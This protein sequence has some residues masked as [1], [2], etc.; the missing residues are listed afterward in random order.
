MA[1]YATAL[2]GGVGR[3]GGSQRPPAQGLPQH[4]ITLFQERSV[5]IDLR[6][7]ADTYT[8]EER[9]GFLRD[10]LGLQTGDIR[11]IFLD[12]STLLLHVALVKHTTFAALR[13]RLF[14]GVKWTAVGDYTVYGWAAAEPL[15]DVRVTGVPKR[16]PSAL[17]RGHFES[18]G[19]VSQ[20][21]RD[22]DR[23]WSSA[24]NGVVRISVRLL[25][26]AV[27][28]HFV[29]VVDSQG[30]LCER[31]AV[32]IN[33]RRRHCFRCGGPGHLGPFCKASCISS[34]APP[35]L[36]STLTYDGPGAATP[37]AAASAAASVTVVPSSIAVDAAISTA[38]V[39]AALSCATG[40]AAPSSAVADSAISAAAIAAAPSRAA[41]DA[42]PSSAV[43]EAVVSAAAVAAVPPGA[44]VDAAPSSVVLEATISA[45]AVVVASPAAAD[46]TAL[47]PAAGRRSSPSRSSSGSSSSASDMSGAEDGG[48]VAEGFQQPR[49]RRKRSPPSG[50]PGS[51]SPSQKS[52]RKE[53][54]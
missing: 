48:P 38:A 5:F 26:G 9:D 49:R 18:L 24:C 50:S 21:S 44:A 20:L 17:L 16:F 37:K 13:D 45:A 34:E 23:T 54:G 14:N 30:V 53:P 2:R 41:V 10:D 42:A 43:L 4:N 32:Y 40:G 22:T 36:W 46:G 7:A 8:L 31:F 25:P 11:D 39:V 52:F 6:A 29:N 35:T 33:G 51:L 1:S 19:P 3:A 47:P 27:V 15:V 12:P 28:P